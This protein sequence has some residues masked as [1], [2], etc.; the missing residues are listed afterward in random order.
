M[1]SVDPPTHAPLLRLLL[2]LLLALALPPS[3]A[4][5][6]PGSPAT[7]TQEL[8]SLPAEYAADALHSPGG[9][10]LLRVVEAGA[11]GWR[12][13]STHRSERGAHHGALL[14]GGRAARGARPHPFA[15][16][17]PAELHGAV[18]PLCERLPY[19]A[20]APPFSR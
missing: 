18:P 3:G 14:S 9:V 17:C 6:G 7:G 16:S 8:R 11:S 4:A 13:G 2:A 10:E 20:T 5:A 15:G 19:F 12:A 1:F